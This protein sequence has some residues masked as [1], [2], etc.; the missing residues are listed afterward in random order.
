MQW[1]VSCGGLKPPRVDNGYCG[2]GDD[3]DSWMGLVWKRNEW[4]KCIDC[5]TCGIRGTFSPS[6]IQ[7]LDAC[8]CSA[9]N[10]IAWLR[11][12]YGGKDYTERYERR[13]AIP[14]Y[15]ITTQRPI[16]AFLLLYL[17]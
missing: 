10:C 6:A 1:V 12:A 4:G 8:T 14:L 9:V 13:D 3:L 2:S 16:V 17:S 5:R 15:G 11:N 7:P